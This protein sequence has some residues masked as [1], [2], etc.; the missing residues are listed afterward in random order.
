MSD[1]RLRLHGFLKE[2]PCGLCFFGIV[3]Q[4][5]AYGAYYSMNLFWNW[6]FLIFFKKSL[7]YF[8]DKYVMIMSKDLVKCNFVE[9]LFLK[10]RNI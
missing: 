8:V 10:I 6:C 7:E 1:H 3:R 4:N 5:P 2:W 9:S